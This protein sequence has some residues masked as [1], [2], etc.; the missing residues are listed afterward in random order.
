MCAK[1]KLLNSLSEEMDDID[2]L[3]LVNNQKSNSAPSSVTSFHFSL[4]NRIGGLARALK[5]FQVA[6]KWLCRHQFRWKNLINCFKKGQWNQ[7]VSHRVE[8]MQA[9]QFGIWDICQFGESGGRRRP[10]AP[11]EQ[12]TQEAIF[13]HKNK[14]QLWEGRRQTIQYKS[15]KARGRLVCEQSY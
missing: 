3:N 10:A 14:R 6:E 7:C 15:G 1:N 11:I 4:K 9:Q 2:V 12:I 13:L 5:V 8:A